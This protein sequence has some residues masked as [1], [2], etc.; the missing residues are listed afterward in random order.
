VVVVGDLRVA[1]HAD[2]HLADVEDH[3]RRVVPA[4]APLVER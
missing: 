4:L 2:E 1:P 3:L